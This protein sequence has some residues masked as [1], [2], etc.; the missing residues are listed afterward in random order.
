MTV[1][2]PSVIS[3]NSR[4]AN[5]M[6]EDDNEMIF[7]HPGS[8][9]P[10]TSIEAGMNYTVRLSLP[11]YSALSDVQSPYT[12]IDLNLEIF[13]GFEGGE[14]ATNSAWDTFQHYRCLENNQSVVKIASTD[15]FS[16]NI[17]SVSALLHPGSKGMAPHSQQSCITA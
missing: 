3:T 2:R 14:V 8:Q 15:I 13:T 4:C 10:K 17:F 6:P 5:T 9:Y 12:L 7:F 1:M 11:L 16:K